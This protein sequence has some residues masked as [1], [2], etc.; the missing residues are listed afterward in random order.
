MNSKNTSNIY[1][2]ILPYLTLFYYHSFIPKELTWNKYGIIM[3][4]AGMGGISMRIFWEIVRTHENLIKEE[5][6]RVIQMHNLGSR[7]KELTWNKYGIIMDIAGMGGISMR[8][9]WE[10]VR[11]HENL[12]KEEVDRVIQMHNLGSR[13]KV[14]L[15]K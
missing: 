5:V 10:I 13:D 9:F 4:I 14:Q 12:I 8:I 6:D 1:Q 11:T 7:D 2:S 15:I 3:D